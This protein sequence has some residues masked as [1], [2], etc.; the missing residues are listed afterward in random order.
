MYAPHSR[1]DYFGVATF[2]FWQC[3]LVTALN[4]E[5]GRPRWSVQTMHLDLW[6]CD[7][8]R[9]RRFPP[10]SHGGLPALL[11]TAKRGQLFLLNGLRAGN[12]HRRAPG[13][14]E[15]RSVRR[16]A[17]NAASVSRHAGDRRRLSKNAGE[18]QRSIAPVPHLVQQH[19]YDVVHAGR[20]RPSLSPQ[21]RWAAQRRVFR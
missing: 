1:N 13:S 17:A 8:P 4:L 7:V 20:S 5:T 19:R 6:D 9:N 18:C 12:L 11:Q 2:N 3:N 16:H 10:D 21:G 15:R 14:A